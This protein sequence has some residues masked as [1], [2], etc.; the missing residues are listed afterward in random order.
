MAIPQLRVTLPFMGWLLLGIGSCVPP[1]QE[2]KL[3]IQNL[4]IQH[5]RPVR[6]YLDTTIIVDLVLAPNGISEIYDT[7]CCFR[8]G[9]AHSIK[10]VVDDTF[11]LQ[12]PLPANK[13]FSQLIISVSSTEKRWDY[14]N[15]AIFQRLSAA[16]KTSASNLDLLA[17]SLYEN[18]II[19]AR[20]LQR[21][22]DD[23]IRISFKE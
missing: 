23:G 11:V 19:P 3:Y 10:V 13:P 5:V 21:P 22:K 7:F 9:P 12:R 1:Q 20:F 6:V 4:D 14:N 18:G 2:F 17:D 8:R 16:G 15:P